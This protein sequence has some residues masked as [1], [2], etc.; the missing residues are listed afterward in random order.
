MKTRN[1]TKKIEKK[2]KSLSCPILEELQE[3]HQSISNYQF[4]ES[5]RQTKNNTYELHK[6]F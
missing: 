6:L 3:Q 5:L 2:V 4:F 1:L